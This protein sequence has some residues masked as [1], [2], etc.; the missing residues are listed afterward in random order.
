LAKRVLGR[1]TLVGKALSFNNERSL[2]FFIDPLRSPATQWLFFFFINPPHLE[3]T[4]WMAVK[5]IPLP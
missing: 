4:Q 3:A 1:S 2:L 5:C